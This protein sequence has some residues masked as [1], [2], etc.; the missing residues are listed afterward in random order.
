[1]DLSDIKEAIARLSPEDRRALT[2][3]LTRVQLQLTPE[4]KAR[5]Q[6]QVDATPDDQWVDWE[7][8]KKEFS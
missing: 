1:M 5:I 8:L 6:Q 3:S 4:E 7:D 2:K